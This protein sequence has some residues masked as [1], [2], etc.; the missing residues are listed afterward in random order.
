MLLAIGNPDTGS[1]SDAS[2]AFDQA[3]ASG[4]PGS[5][6]STGD[7]VL[8]HLAAA[9]A[10]VATTLGWP[11]AA[12]TSKELDALL[13]GISEGVTAMREGGLRGAEADVDDGRT[14][15]GQ[16]LQDHFW[17]SVRLGVPCP[18]APGESARTTLLLPSIEEAHR[19]EAHLPDG[20][21]VLSSATR[22]GQEPWNAFDARPESV[23]NAGAHS[24]PQW[25][26]IDLGRPSTIRA[27]RL[28]I[29]QALEGETVHQVTVRGPSGSDQLLTEFRGIT[30]DG[31]LL[32]STLEVPL[33]KIRFVRVTTLKTPALVSWRE[34]EIITEAE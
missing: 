7:A 13:A 4:D 20:R 5:I 12:D 10:A 25:I 23:W 21:L 26:E 22:W 30:R 33:D 8:G 9:R 32:E 24:V 15:M 11:P 1:A 34:I 6:R 31:Q 3:L 2:K 28:L 17:P 29:A 16:A 14:R 19:F 27:I 18:P